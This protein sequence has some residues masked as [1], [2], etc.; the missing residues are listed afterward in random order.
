MNEHQKEVFSNPALLREKL[1]IYLQ[2]PEKVEIYAESFEKFFEAGNRN[3]IKFKATWSWWAL[4]GGLFFYLYR[5]DYKMA[6]IYF[7]LSL[8]PIVSLVALL[9]PAYAKY[10]ICDKF[11]KALALNN[12]EFLKNEG[13]VNKWAIYLAV[14]L[15]VLVICLILF[16]ASIG[17]YS[18]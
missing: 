6:I 8:I 7:I 1:G 5:K 17:A 2:T 16:A 4:F 3:E 15:F 11:C 14:V 10:S 13:G 18:Y 12:D 9:I